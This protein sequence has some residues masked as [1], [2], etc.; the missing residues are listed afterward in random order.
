MG[1]SAMY[2]EGSPQSKLKRLLIIFISTSS[3][4]I[5]SIFSSYKIKTS[6]YKSCSTL[7]SQNQWWWNRLSFWIEN[8][9]ISTFGNKLFEH[10]ISILKREFY[11]NDWPNILFTDDG[12][13]NIARKIYLMVELHY[14]FQHDVSHNKVLQSF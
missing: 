10:I 6:W 7:I 4:F 11:A 13:N 3:L 9:N 1:I 8:F 2:G 14:F 5:K 12:D